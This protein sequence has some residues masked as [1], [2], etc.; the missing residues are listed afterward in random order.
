[1]ASYVSFR[2]RRLRRRRCYCGLARSVCRRTRATGGGERGGEVTFVVVVVVV[3]VVIVV[4]GRGRRRRGRG[5]DQRRE[6]F[7]EP[8]RL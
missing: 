4:W 2:L 7:V 5:E 8:N 3:V 6:I 1:M